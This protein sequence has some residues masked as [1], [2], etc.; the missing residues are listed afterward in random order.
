M[1]TPTTNEDCTR[2]DLSVE[3]FYAKT[4]E[5]LTT[6]RN[7]LNFSTFRPPVC[8]RNRRRGCGRRHAFVRILGADDEIRFQS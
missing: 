7:T 4:L 3:V 1:R 2:I 8:D 6:K 5:A